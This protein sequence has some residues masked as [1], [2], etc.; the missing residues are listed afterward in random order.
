M[1]I[2]LAELVTDTAQPFWMLAISLAVV[3]LLITVVVYGAVGLIV[4][5]DDVGLH[6][7]GRKSGGARALGRGLVRAMPVL[8]KA[9]SVIGIAAMIWVGGHIIVAGLNAMGV[10]E[11]Y[12]SFHVVA[13]AVA[14]GLPAIHGFAEWLT[15]TV[16]DFIA[17]LTVGGLIVAVHHMFKRH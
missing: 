9:L 7:A 16:L 12:H 6:L 11:P 8:M 3:G 1:A 4:K 15:T 13:E 17:G 2:A 10:T 14:H 5:M